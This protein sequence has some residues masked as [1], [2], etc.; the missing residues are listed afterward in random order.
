MTISEIF[1][2]L[3]NI[4]PYSEVE[5]ED[6][7]PDGSLRIPAESLLTV[8]EK[9][10][11]DAALHFECLKCLSAVD[12][13]DTLQV[14]YH[15]YSIKNHHH[16]ALR[17]VVPKDNPVVPTASGIWLAAE[18]HEREAYD[19]MGIRFDRHPDPRRIL[20]PDDWEGY[21]LRK[22]YISPSEFHGIPLTAILPSELPT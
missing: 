13:G 21:P 20:C 16:L 11:S 8:G 7:Q 2:H 6:I 22:D 19:M 14:V 12:R 10:K 17:V 18:W 15:L 5:L 9:L 1:D 3:K 4:A